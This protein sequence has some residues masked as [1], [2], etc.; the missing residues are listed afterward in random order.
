MDPSFDCSIMLSLPDLALV[1]K[2]FYK[3]GE[4]ATKALRQLRTLKGIKAK[5]NPISLKGILN[6]VHRFEE[7]GRLEHRPRS[8]RPSVSANR[9]PVVQSVM[10]NVAAETSTGSCSAR[11]AGKVTGIPER[12]VRRIL[13]LIL[14]MHPYKI[15]ARHQLLPADCDKRHAFATWALAQMDRDPQWLLNIMWTDEAHFSLHGE[16][17]TQNSRIWATSNP[18]AYT[19]KPLHSPHV[20]V[21][22]GFTASFIIGPLFFEERCPV[23]GWK[24]CSVT[25]ERYLTLLNDHVVPALQ[26]R[27]ALSSVTFMQDGAPP[28]VSRSVKTF[29]LSKFTEDRLISRGCKNAWPARSPDLT[30]ADFW[31]W[32]YLKSR[33][34]RGSPATLVELKDAIQ[35]AVSGIDADMLHA[36]VLGVVTRLTCLLPCGGGHVEHLL[37]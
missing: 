13:H 6:V 26:Q 29:L 34:Y 18:H 28:H 16:V 19:T 4:S 2:L 36:A 17:N 23:S 9:V 21:W 25:A 32:G 33:V 3:N 1:V 5:K 30:P 27:R 11:E 24:T 31:L 8:G 12:S 7:T 15:Q 35:L 20:T 22:C 14:E 37:F 10:R